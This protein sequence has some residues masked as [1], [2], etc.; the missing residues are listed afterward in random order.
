MVAPTPDGPW[1][2]DAMLETCQL[3][4]SALRDYLRCSAYLRWRHSLRFFME[5]QVEFPET[6]LRVYDTKSGQSQAFRE[7]HVAR[8]E[9]P[10]RYRLETR[11]AGKRWNSKRRRTHFVSWG[12]R[13]LMV[14]NH[15]NYDRFGNEWFTAAPQAPR[16]ARYRDKGRRKS[17]TLDAMNL[18]P[19]AESF[20]KKRRLVVRYA[21]TV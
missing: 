4:Q 1:A 3:W 6:P 10:S 14:L 7:H 8:L 13:A 9:Q 2:I 5:L 19:E 17:A 20:V 11:H 15:P 18:C 21:P 16:G 12:S